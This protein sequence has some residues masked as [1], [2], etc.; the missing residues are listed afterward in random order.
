MK[1]NPLSG[2]LLPHVIRAYEWQPR[3][4]TQ[5]RGVLQ[6][7]TGQDVFALKPVKAEA[8][9]LA[10][11]HRIISRLHEHN[12]P[13]VLPWIKTKYGDAFYAGKEMSF[14]A[15]PWFGKE[16]SRDTS[17]PED[18]LIQSLADMHRLTEN[19]DAQDD[20]A[21]GSS[22]DQTIQRWNKQ[23]EQLALYVDE[24]RKREQASPFDVAF[25][26]GHDE[27]IQAASFALNGLTRMSEID[28]ERPFR[29]VFCHRHIHR[30]NLL[31]GEENWKWIDFTHAGID[32]PMW[33][34][35]TFIHRFPPQEEDAFVTLET[36]LDTY[37][38]SFTLNQR[39]RQLLGL[40]LAYP[41]SVI[42]WLNRYYT[43]KRSHSEIF[44]VQ[45]LENALQ[46]FK[47]L[48][49][50]VKHIWPQRESA[51]KQRAALKQ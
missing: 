41:E 46:Y 17:I 23:M 40:F 12:Y 4:V 45:G 6:I 24:A 30:H 38:E 8:S 1:G 13:H 51:K 48:K 15:T 2:K 32:I 26:D 33:D 10:F 44:Y 50:F 21:E 25:L 39:E 14:Y 18:T 22:L 27:L 19:V 47:V 43:H 9:R 29:R 28:A 36:W 37:E 16:W 5:V 11:L 35:A 34:L 20:G 49:R 7:Q 31:I 3:K 42:E